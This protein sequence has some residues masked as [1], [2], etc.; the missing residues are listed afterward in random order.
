MYFWI[1]DTG[2]NVIKLTPMAL[3]YIER[4]MLYTVS[5][6][7]II[8]NSIE[9]EYVLALIIIFRKNA[10]VGRIFRVRKLLYCTLTERRFR[11]LFFRKLQY[12]TDC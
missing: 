9:R 10:S 4:F 8:F 12:Q 5:T 1:E 6:L 7:I 2:D 3:P 11:S